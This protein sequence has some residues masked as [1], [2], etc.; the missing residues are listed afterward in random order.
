MSW[1]YI[2]E[3]VKKTYRKDIA[4]SSRAN[5]VEDDWWDK[6]PDDKK[7]VE[8]KIEEEYGDVDVREDATKI[9]EVSNVFTKPLEQAASDSGC[10]WFSRWHWT[11]TVG[12]N[13]GRYLLGIKVAETD[14]VVTPERV[15]HN[16]QRDHKQKTKFTRR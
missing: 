14:C 5:N 7:R 12:Q 1:G 3:L 9:H 13:W 8:N 11:V 6:N 2:L 4:G 10:S 16:Q 15:N